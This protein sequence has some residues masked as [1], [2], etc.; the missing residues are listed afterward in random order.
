MFE[1]LLTHAQLN[2]A[3]KDNHQNF[4]L[5]GAAV[6]DRAREKAVDPQ[7]TECLKPGS[8]LVDIDRTGH[9]IRDACELHRSVVVSLDDIHGLTSGFLAALGKLRQ[10]LLMSLEKI[11]R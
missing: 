9:S 7:R 5:F 4:I 1:F 10:V 11:A 8:S 2:G 3:S 6:H